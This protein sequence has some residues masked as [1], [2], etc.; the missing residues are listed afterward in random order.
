[1]ISG[2]YVMKK[3]TKKTVKRTP[4]NFSLKE[5][6]NYLSLDEQ[7][8]DK[9]LT[10]TLLIARMLRLVDLEKEVNSL[11]EKSLQFDELAGSL[12]KILN[13]Q[14]YNNDFPL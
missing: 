11:R 2:E 8:G 5:L 4:T 13:K 3:K 7:C 1:M 12:K 9:K 14:Q 10:K 6:T